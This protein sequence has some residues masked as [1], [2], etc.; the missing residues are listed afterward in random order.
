MKKLQK[1]FTL[2]ELIV[3][4]T[5]LAIL[6]TIAFISLQGY[7]QD[8]KNSKVTSDL[9]SLVSGIEIALTDGTLSGIKDL[10]DNTSAGDALD[11]AGDNVVATTESI[12]I[13]DTLNNRS[14]GALDSSGA[15]YDVGIVDF[16]AIRQSGEDFVDSGFNNYV[17]AAAYSGATAYYQLAG[18]KKEASGAYTSIIKGN[19][20]AQEDDADSLV[21]ASG[22]TT[23]VV[24]DFLFPTDDDDFY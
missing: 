3:V 22:S 4:I 15:T 13:F 18:Q 16:A 12:S 6:G 11:Y 1:G 24:N 21:S 20:V 8:A 10:V 14:T 7:S 9:R 2:V 19:Y 17:A 5:I 23:A